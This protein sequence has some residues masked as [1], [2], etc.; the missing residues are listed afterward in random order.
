MQE[1]DTMKLR[2][3]III[4]FIVI[5]IV[6]IT[7]YSGVLDKSKSHQNKTGK[8]LETKDKLT[9][10]TQ[11]Y[12]EK[13]LTINQITEDREKLIQLV[14]DVHPY[15]LLEKDQSKYND[16]KQ[17]YINNTNN[18][19]TAIEFQKISATFL[20]FFQDGHTS[21]TWKER[22]YIDVDW[23]YNKDG[24]YL[25]EDG[26][27]TNKKI[28]TINDIPIQRVFD[29]IDAIFPA[30]NDMGHS[31]N[32]STY[33]KG[34]ELLKIA[35]ISVKD[36]A[37]LKFSDQSKKSC[38][39]TSHPNT[40]YSNRNYGE[41]Q[42]DIYYI[43]F[44]L[45]ESDLNFQTTIEDL[46]KAIKSGVNKVIIDVRNNPGGDS[47]TCEMILNTLGME[48]PEYSGF[49]R[50]SKE[51]SE[52]RGYS[53]KSGSE[54][55]TGTYMGKLNK[56][57]KLV[58]LTNRY[59]YSSATMLAVW[60]KDGH[61]GTVIGESSSNNPCSYGDILSFQLPNSLFEIHISH[62]KFLRP[63]KSKYNQNELTPDILVDVN[64]DMYSVAVNWLNQ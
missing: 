49:I 26:E 48:V 56:K 7:Y 20:N 8:Q 1:E 40:I 35:G 44:G 10:K 18:S 31:A 61:L 6:G 53:K 62:K 16:A 19:M 9:T 4:I 45:C 64:E 22:L 34:V 36:M 47:G 12:E 57:I 58:V 60:I 14:E 25:V 37:T 39:I 63:D 23:I 41:V 3:N 51:A 2:N 28:I 55:Y 29:M 52:Q 15:F 46:K 11:S 33:S 54:K 17:A 30:E 5:G 42:G 50:F 27:V 59:T 32:Y 13:E 21:L 38:H 43:D 24:L